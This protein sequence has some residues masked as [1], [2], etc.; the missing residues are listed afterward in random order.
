MPGK[1]NALSDEEAIKASYFASTAPILSASGF[2][3]AG[4]LQESSSITPEFTPEA[5]EDFNL[6]EGHPIAG[7]PTRFGSGPGSQKRSAGPSSDSHW[8]RKRPSMRPEAVGAHMKAAEPIKTSIDLSSL[9]SMQVAHAAKRQTREER[10]MAN[11]TDTAEELITDG[12]RYVPGED[13][14]VRLLVAGNEK[15]MFG[16][17]VGQPKGDLWREVVEAV[18]RL[19][20][21]EGAQANA[22]PRKSPSIYT[23][24]GRGER[25]AGGHLL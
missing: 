18:T 1:D 5:E 17:I 4:L 14:G 19:M 22:N 9:P 24:A 8:R 10:A 25:P 7:P 21:K 2:D 23:A 15:K 20:L 6:L 3:F 16:A 13:N 12:F 11:A